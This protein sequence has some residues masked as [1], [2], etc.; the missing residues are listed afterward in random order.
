MSDPEDHRKLHDELEREAGEME[1]AGDELGEDT[2][3]VRADWEQK[4]ADEGVPG[5]EAEPE[6]GP[7]VKRREDVEPEAEREPDP[8]P[9]A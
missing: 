3:A 7:V 5:A 2:R 9:E 6:D 4:Q 8:E 1:E